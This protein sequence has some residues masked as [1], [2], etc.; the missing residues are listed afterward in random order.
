M[1]RVTM[2]FLGVLLLSG[3][4]SLPAAADSNNGDTCDWKTDIERQQKWLDW[5]DEH[6]KGAATPKTQNTYDDEVRFQTK[7]LPD[8]L[9]DTTSTDENTQT[10]L[11]CGHY[12]ENTSTCE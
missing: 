1:K 7:Q 11:A 9:Q 10:L 4:V 2:T 8:L 12:N 5:V 6:Q 3:A